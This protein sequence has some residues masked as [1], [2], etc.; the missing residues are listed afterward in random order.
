VKRWVAI[1]G[2]AV[3]ALGVGYW[4]A[5]QRHVGDVSVLTDLQGSDLSWM[6][7]EFNLSDEQFAAVS[8]VHQG[9]AAVCS[10][11]CIAIVAAQREV[12]VSRAR[13]PDSEAT[14]AAEQELR[15]LE[16]TCNDATMAHLRTVAELMPP[17]AGRRFLTLV[18][19]HVASQPHDGDRGLDR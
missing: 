17:A 9:Y 18:E 1:L 12:D 8:A 13:A 7:T 10:Q 3:L 14:V 2:L 16:N 19:P 11:H 15:D 5:G 6:Q 4:F